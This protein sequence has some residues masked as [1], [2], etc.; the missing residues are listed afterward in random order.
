MAKPS[1]ASADHDEDEFY[2]H[3]DPQS[4]KYRVIGA[5]IILLSC[6]FAWW[7][8]LDHESKRYESIES[9]VKEP[10]NIERFEIPLDVIEKQQ[11]YKQRRQDS[12]V[13]PDAL[14]SDDIASPSSTD[15]V[16][17][18]VAASI[19]T[20]NKVYDRPEVA[21]VKP[22]SVEVELSADSTQNK[23]Q[24][25][26]LA[27]AWVLQLG[28]FTDKKNAESLRQKLYKSDVSAYVKRFNLSGRA[29]YRVIVG[30]KFD[31]RSVE[32]MQTSVRKKSGIQPLIVKF[33]S[34]F[35]Q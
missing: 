16:S 28:S 8:F 17:K 24:L 25:P 30:P 4:I 35:E 31:R 18:P 9:I 7:A 26:A 19:K 14:N 12:S 32:K 15:K 2:T 27:D 29:I 11:Q 33:T 3:S 10:L 22:M 34:G 13:N 23:R 1:L 5:S 6:S 20:D 21:S